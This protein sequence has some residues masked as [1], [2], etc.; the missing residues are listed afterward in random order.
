MKLEIP[1]EI[2]KVAGL[3]EKDCLVELALHLYAEKK[4]PFAHALRLS[5]LSR[6]Q[7]E[8]ELAKRDLTVYSLEDLHQDVEAL[9]ELGRL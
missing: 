2:L 5:D 9:R 4:I 7:F 6:P 3:T 8:A 1:E